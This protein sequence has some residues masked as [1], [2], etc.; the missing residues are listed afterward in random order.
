MK[1]S[2]SPGPSSGNRNV[3]RRA[4]SISRRVSGI[5]HR[6]LIRSR[7][8]ADHIAGARAMLLRHP[9]R[10]EIASRAQREDGMARM[11]MDAGTRVRADLGAGGAVGRVLDATAAVRTRLAGPGGYYNVGNAVGLGMGVAPPAHRRPGRRARDAVG[12][13]GRLGVPGRQCRRGGADGRDGG[14]LPERRGLPPGLG[15]RRAA[16]GCAE[17]SRRPAVGHRRA[18]PRHRAAQPRAGDARGDRRGS[19]CARQVRQRLPLAH[20]ARMAFGV[21]QLL[22]HRS[23]GEPRPGDPRRADRAR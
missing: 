14:V 12:R 4:S 15:A 5:G 22:P 20:A 21:A 8:D 23:A 1:R 18:D 10:R 11:V 7:C 6:L 16:Q 13:H 17:P 2:R 3:P 9:R 19:A